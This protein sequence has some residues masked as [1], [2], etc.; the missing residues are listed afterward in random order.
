MPVDCLQCLERAKT[1]A[2]LPVRLH[3]SEEMKR[4]ALSHCVTKP[5]SLAQQMK[6]LQPA[7]LA[8]TTRLNFT[9]LTF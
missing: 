4:V 9:A 2:N 3:S 1:F 5:P 8:P 7:Q 6:L